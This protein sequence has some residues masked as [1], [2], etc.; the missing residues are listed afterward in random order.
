[1]KQMLY[2]WNLTHPTALIFAQGLESL[3]LKQTIQ[4]TH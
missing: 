4:A 1:M 3:L 2:G